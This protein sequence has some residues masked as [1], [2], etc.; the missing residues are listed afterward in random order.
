[1]QRMGRN[2]EFARCLELLRTKYKIK[3]N[4]IK[5]LN[6]NDQSLYLS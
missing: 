1:M 6:E 2:D 4:F 3:R 5:L